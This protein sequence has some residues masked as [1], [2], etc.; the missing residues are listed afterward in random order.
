MIYNEIISKE[1]EVI[2]TLTECEGILV[3]SFVTV[4]LTLTYTNWMTVNQSNIYV[5][6]SVPSVLINHINH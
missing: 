2:E 3:P 6:V 4:R 1:S 5:C